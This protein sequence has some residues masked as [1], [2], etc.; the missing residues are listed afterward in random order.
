MRRIFNNRIEAILVGALL[1]GLAT[2]VFKPAVH[3]MF[4]KSME[5]TPSLIDQILE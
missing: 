5:K 3:A 2:M 4:V 1:V